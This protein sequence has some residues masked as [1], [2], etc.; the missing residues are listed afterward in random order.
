MTGSRKVQGRTKLVQ[1]LMP[2]LNEELSIKQLVTE[3]MLDPCVSEVVVIDNNSTDQTMQLA[4]EAGA[5]VISCLLPG[6]GAAIKLGIENWL[7]TSSGTAL[8]IVE[9]DGTFASNDLHKFYAYYDDADI[10]TG[11]RT[12]KSL[13]WDG[14][15][16]PFWV[17]IGNWF[18]AKLTEFLYN[19]PSLTD[20]GCTAKFIK[21]GAISMAKVLE[22]TDRSHFNEQFM[23]YLLESKKKVIEIPVN[24]KP[25]IGISKIT[26]GNTWTTLRLGIRM[27]VD[28]ILYRFFRHRIA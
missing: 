10:I 9:S 21:P 25:R 24:Y 14:S 12:S 19:G 11:S 6:F 28:V 18:V 20:I 2:A 3:Y 13:I 27:I 15:Y 5:L 17:K 7:E 1:V 23:V 8:F 22:L 26:G 4:Q 16:M